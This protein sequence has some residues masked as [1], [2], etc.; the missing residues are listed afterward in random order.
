MKEIKNSQLACLDDQRG[1]AIDSDIPEFLKNDGHFVRHELKLCTSLESIR[2]RP[3]PRHS[4]IS[5]ANLNLNSCKRNDNPLT[6]CDKNMSSSQNTGKLLLNIK[7][8]LIKF[9]FFIKLQ[10]L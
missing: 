5:K 4:L 1:I 7:F 10:N 3:A 6:K 8:V 2:P 9:A